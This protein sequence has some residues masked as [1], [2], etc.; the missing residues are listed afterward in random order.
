[1]SH[2]KAKYASALNERNP[3]KIAESNVDVNFEKAQKLL[4]SQKRR[5]EYPEPHQD[6]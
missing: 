1:M 4:K 6:P 5:V 2:L 3:I